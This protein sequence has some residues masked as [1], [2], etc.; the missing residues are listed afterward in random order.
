M[1][2][3]AD[4]LLGSPYAEE[5]ELRRYKLNNEIVRGSKV[6]FESTLFLVFSTNS[7]CRELFEKFSGALK[8][9]TRPQTE[10]MTRKLIDD[11]G[12][13]FREDPGLLEEKEKESEEESNDD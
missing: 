6:L 5:A 7:D 12:E 2:G 8:D 10:M 1:D 9:F 3:E 11:W 13:R 4:Y